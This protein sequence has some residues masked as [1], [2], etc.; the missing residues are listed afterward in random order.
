MI[1]GMNFATFFFTVVSASALSVPNV[2]PIKP[3]MIAVTGA[4]GRTGSLVVEQ[5]VDRGMNVVAL[6]RDLEKAE[7]KLP[8]SDKIKVVKC[9]LG[10]EIDIIDAIEGCD[11]AIWCAT[12]FSDAPDQ[13]IMGKIANI[14]GVALNPKKSIDAV[15]VPAL[16]KYF[17]S[18][19]GEKE[20]EPLPKVIML[21]SA[22]VTRPS[23][24]EKKKAEFAGCA[25]IPIVRL[26]P[27][28]ILD[29]KADSEER[30]RKSGE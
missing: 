17:A 1:T 29:I 4:T 12:G 21:S 5:L 15:G 6:V 25:D 8:S 19:S 10:N 13:T 30:L 11:A 7:E 26:N 9:D 28:G 16:A 27:F 3:Q 2:A 20:E 22:G 14:F 18:N 24:D 23:W